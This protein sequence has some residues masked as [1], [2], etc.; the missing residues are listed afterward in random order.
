MRKFTLAV[1]GTGALALGLAA[2]GG[3]AGGAEAETEIRFG[4]VVSAETTQQRAYEH[5]KDLVED[6]SDG[7]ITVDIYPDGALGG[8]REMVESTQVGD[9]QMTA[10]SIG[11]LANFDDTLEV[12]DFP[13][14]FDDVETAHAVLDSEVGMSLLE[15]VQDNGLL[16][17]GYGENGYRHLSNSGGEIRLP[18]EA[19]GMQLRTMEVPM[20]IAYWRSI[21]VNP[22]PLAFTE[23]FSALQ[24]GVVDGVENPLQLIYTGNFYEP[25]PYITMTGHIYDPEPILINKDFFDGLSEEDQEII[26]SS[27]GE[28]ITELRGFNADVEADL[29]AELEAEGVTFTDLT[30]DERQAWVETAVAF[31]QDEA[32]NVDTDRLRDLLEA[33]GND[34]LLAAT[35]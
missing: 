24:Q 23:V 2:C 18:E 28:A 16:A 29:R 13:F 15:G 26:R 34:V 22:T 33:A 17:L 21:G 5:F 31:Y 32:G 8:E 20:H 35:D 30:D 4:H 7:R 12:F 3:D 19:A 11:V 1:A 14:I 27:A 9:I 25:S 6:R 10:P